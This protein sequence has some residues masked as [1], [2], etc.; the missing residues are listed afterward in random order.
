MFGIARLIHFVFNLYALGLLIYVVLGWIQ[1]PST[2]GARR[3]L[4]KFYL[5]FL[6]PLRQTIKPTNLGGNWVDLTPLVLLLLI[7][8][9]RYILISLLTGMP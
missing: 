8:V 5:P 9:A 1:N 4:E 3:W 7:W 2:E 6:T